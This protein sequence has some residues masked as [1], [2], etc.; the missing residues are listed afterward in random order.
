MFHCWHRL[1]DC[2]M[3]RF[4]RHR[5]DR[6]TRVDRDMWN[7]W[8]HQ[9]KYHHW[10][11]D[12]MN[13]DWFWFRS[14]HLC[15][16]RMDRDSHIHLAKN[17][18]SFVYHSHPTWSIGYPYLIDTKSFN[19]RWTFTIIDFDLTIR[20]RETLSTLA[21]VIPNMINTWTTIQ[22][23]IGETFIR[24]SFAIQTNIIIQT[25]ASISIKQRNT[26]PVI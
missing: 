7:H 24:C 3:D 6:K 10:D 11:K 2:N 22:T 4:F 19:T 21:C 5:S 12:Q 13:T 23:G 18:E 25:N 9:Y 14:E 20:S 26:K 17:R 1:M 15:R 16:Q 8:L